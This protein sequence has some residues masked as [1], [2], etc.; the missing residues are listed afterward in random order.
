MHIRYNPDNH[1]SD[2]LDYLQLRLLSEEDLVFITADRRLARVASR[3]PESDR[4]YIWDELVSLAGDFLS[5][6]R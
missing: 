6:E 5:D 2:Y 1:P 4:I 3:S